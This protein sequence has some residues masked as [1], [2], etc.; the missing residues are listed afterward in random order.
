M[1]RRSGVGEDV[2]VRTAR[3]HTL[4]RETMPQNTNRA[5]I[6]GD[7]F[8]DLNV[9]ASPGRHGTEQAN[10]PTPGGSGG[11]GERPGKGTARKTVR[12]GRDP[13]TKN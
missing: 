8:V 6:F 5:G 1:G 3:M 11:E 10:P 2:P 7:S 13:L 12:G 4:C 9:K